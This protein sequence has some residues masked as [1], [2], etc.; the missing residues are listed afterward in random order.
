MFELHG[1]FFK[2]EI[3]TTKEIV[4]IIKNNNNRGFEQMDIQEKLKLSESLDE[5]LAINNDFK[6]LKSLYQCEAQDNANI[7]NFKNYI[8]RA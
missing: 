7:E 8:R 4:D 2:R 5:V 1:K 6:D 3:F